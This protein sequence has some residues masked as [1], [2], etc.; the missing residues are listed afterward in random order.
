MCLTCCPLPNCSVTVVRLQGQQ[1]KLGPPQLTQTILPA[2]PSAAVALAQPEWIYHT[3]AG[4]STGSP[5]A[6]GA[7]A[8]TPNDAMYSAA[9]RSSGLWF[10]PKIQAPAA[11][12]TTVGSGAVGVCM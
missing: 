8:A 11:W 6:A 5:A 1:H 10:L 3:Q 12:E 9:E 2:S 7:T 4:P